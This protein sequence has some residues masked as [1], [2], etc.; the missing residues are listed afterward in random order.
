MSKQNAKA[1]A[2]PAKSTGKKINRKRLNAMQR[3][4]LPKAM[5]ILWAGSDRSWFR[6]LLKNWEA[7][8]KR[9]PAE[10]QG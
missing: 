7:G 6:E 3:K 10:E 8:R 9:R 2:A 5:K 4:C 1:A